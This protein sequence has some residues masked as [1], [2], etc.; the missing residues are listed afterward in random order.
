LAF[1]GLFDLRLDNASYFFYNLKNTSVLLGGAYMGDEK[2]FLSGNEEIVLLAVANLGVQAYGVPIYEMVERAAGKVASIGAIYATLERLQDR[3]LVSSWMGE[4]TQE[5]G[6]KAKKY[7]KIEAPGVQALQQAEET[8]KVLRPA[9]IPTF[10][11][12][13][14]AT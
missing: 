7:F 9:W 13:G 10:M 12:S 5:R 4:A 8:R 14:G 6:G 1:F 2:L 11:P 3:G